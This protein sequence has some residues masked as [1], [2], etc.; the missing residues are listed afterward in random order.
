MGQEPQW[1]GRVA[2][3]NVA[4]CGAELDPS[5]LKDDAPSTVWMAGPAVPRLDPTVTLSG[6]QGAVAYFTTCS[7]LAGSRRRRTLAPADT[8]LAEPCCADSGR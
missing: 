8:R 7:P 5:R 1:V 6:R 3:I 2:P 4:H